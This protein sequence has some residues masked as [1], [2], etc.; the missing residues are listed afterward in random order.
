MTE[1]LTAADVSRLMG[2]QSAEIRAGTAEK[3]ATHFQYGALTESERRIAADIFRSMLEDAEVRVREALTRNLKRCPD[4]PRDIARRLADDVESVAVPMLQFSEVLT[5]ADLIEIARLQNTVKQTA[6]AKRA[7]VSEG[8]ADALL[9]TGNEA[10]VATLVGNNGARISEPALHKVVENFGDSEAVQ[11]PLV[12]RAALPVTVAERLVSK[13][14]DSL[15]EYLVTHHELPPNLASDLILDTRERATVSLLGRN[16]TG[17]DLERLVAQLHE[18]GRLTPSLILRAACVG[19]IGFMETSL[20]ALAGVSLV[21][22]RVLVNE[23]GN[24]GL[25][26]IYERAGLPAE[27]FPAFRAAVDV[28][29]QTQYDGEDQDRERFARRVLERIITQV[30]TIGGDMGQENVD[31]LLRKLDRLVDAAPSPLH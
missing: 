25:R 7:T 20:A 29:Q 1:T 22:T 21:N 6:I 15:R 14:S 12:R 2:D 9:D 27:F 17:V 26:S 18:N 28:A 3:I 4:L 30:E 11:Q 10:V 19:D 24:L 5:D 13:V 31:Y 8:V 23:A 16:K